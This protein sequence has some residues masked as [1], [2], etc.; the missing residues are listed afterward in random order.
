MDGPDGWAD[1]RRASTPRPPR[2]LVGPGQGVRVH[3]DTS[4]ACH[5][6]HDDQWLL[7]AST[8]V[9]VLTGGD[10]RPARPDAVASLGP[11]RG[12]G[13]HG[14]RRKA[15]NR[16]RKGPPPRRVAGLFS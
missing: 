3:I 14:R 11:R 15:A 8:G 16:T 12:P 1:G 7:R 2:F 9:L 5:D 10:Y 6:V 4:N 13:S